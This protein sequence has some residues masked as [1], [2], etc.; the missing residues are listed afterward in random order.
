MNIFIQNELV[1]FRNAYA[2]TNTY[3]HATTINDKDAMN[4]RDME[5]EKVQSFGWVEGGR[6]EKIV[7]LY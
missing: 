1:V 2:Y 7:Y 5:K 6:R 3:M 4:L